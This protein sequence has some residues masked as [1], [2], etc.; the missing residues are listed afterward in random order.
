MCCRGKEFVGVLSREG[1]GRCAVMKLYRYYIN[2]GG[3]ELVSPL[4]WI[5]K[6]N[7]LV[8][9]PNLGFCDTKQLSHML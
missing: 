1:V 5:G 4:Q 2:I 6:E 3:G 7:V 8:L 9:E